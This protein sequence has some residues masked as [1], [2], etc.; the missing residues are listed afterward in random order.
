MSINLIMPMGGAGTRFARDGY[1]CPK[2]LLDLNGRHFFEY[3]ADSLMKN[4]D[5][6]SITFVVLKDHV[7]RFSIDTSIRKYAPDARIVILDHVLNG[8]V[9]TSIEGAKTIDNDLPLIFCDCDLMFRSDKLYQYVRDGSYNGTGLDGWLV[10]FE[11]SDGRFSYVKTDEQGF[12][13]ETAEKKPISSR[14]VC[15]AYGFGNKN[16]FLENA[17]KYMDN[18]PYDEYFMSGIYNLM[19]KEGL[20]VGEFPTDS[21]LSFGTPEEYINAKETLTN[22]DPDK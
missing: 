17:D 1:E 19:I 11:N 12:V 10:T 22:A 8:A 9:L 13:I 16:I 4:C 20:K 14:A 7:E 21:F 6:E 2:P 15:G 3:A 5:I 18:C